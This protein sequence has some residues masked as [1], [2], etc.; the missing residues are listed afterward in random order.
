MPCRRSVRSQGKFVG[1]GR[2]ACAEFARRSHPICLALFLV[3]TPV[4][5]AAQDGASRLERR[6]HAMG[7]ELRLEIEAA[8]RAEA[9]AASEAAVGAVEEVESRWSAWREDSEIVRLNRAPLGE[10]LLLSEAFRR[11]LAPALRWCE[12]T[13]GAFNPLAGALVDA[14]G[15]REGGR[16]PSETE[17]GLAVA[18]CRVGAV[19][20]DLDGTATRR[21][22]DASLAS[23]GFAKGVALDA[24]S[25]ALL[26]TGTIQ[27]ALLDFG[28]QTLLV[29]DAWSERGATVDLADPRE[30]TQPVVRMLISHGSTATSGNAERS[31]VVE[32]ERLGHLLDPRTGRPAPDFG[33]LTV[34]APDATDADCLSTGLYVLGPAEALGFARRH[35]GVE[36]LILEPK[37]EGIRARASSGFRELLVVLDPRVTLEW[38]VSLTAHRVLELTMDED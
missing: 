36:V 9:I 16:R 25:A 17:R 31:F 10:P 22:A 21:V 13:H 3:T 18:A 35:D 19:H 38:G 32:G 7:T 5:A 24:A 20:I 37:G 6:V 28:G 29:G 4:V 27:R 8:T 26:G 15:L 34:W 11:D 14:W 33:S 30:R 2:L 23:G 12:A 1:T